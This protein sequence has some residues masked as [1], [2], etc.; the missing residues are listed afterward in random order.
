MQFPLL[1]KLLQVPTILEQLRQ[2]RQQGLG[3]VEERDGEASE[4]DEC[5]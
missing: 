4:R 5:Q 2:P 3:G 1:M